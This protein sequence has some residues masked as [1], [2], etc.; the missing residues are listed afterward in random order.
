MCFSALKSTVREEDNQLF[1][2]IIDYL[3]YY[4]LY[5]SHRMGIE[6]KYIYAE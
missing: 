4:Y 2:C 3:S 5:A 1:Q 6:A